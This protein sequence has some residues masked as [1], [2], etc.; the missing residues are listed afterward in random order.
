MFSEVIVMIVYCVPY[1]NS[2]ISYSLC[3][4]A[5]AVT[6]VTSFKEEGYLNRDT[7]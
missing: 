6:V 1:K 5:N 3:V 4:R 2:G 7:S